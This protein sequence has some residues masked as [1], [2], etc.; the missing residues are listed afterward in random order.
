M[1]PRLWIWQRYL[2]ICQSLI[3][4]LVKL[5]L[6]SKNRSKSLVFN[7]LSIKMKTLGVLKKLE[8][9]TTLKILLVSMIKTSDYKAF[10][11]Q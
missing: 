10:I 6:F 1:T 5:H 9:T 3:I 11:A 2:E 4:L 8:N 7:K